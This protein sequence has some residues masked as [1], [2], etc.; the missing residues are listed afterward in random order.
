[1]GGLNVCIPFL[2]NQFKENHKE[3]HVG[4]CEEPIKL[5]GLEG[6]IQAEQR[7]SEHKV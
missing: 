4:L 2:G 7:R 6:R 3:R 1:M 5:P